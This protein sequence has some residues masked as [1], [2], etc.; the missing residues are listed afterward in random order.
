MMKERHFLLPVIGVITDTCFVLIPA[1][2]N[3]FRPSIN[4]C[5]YGL[6]SSTQDLCFLQ[7]KRKY[8][9]PKKFMIALFQ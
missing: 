8:Q 2:Y 5:D 6:K 3:A 9:R 7:L 1:F 4:D